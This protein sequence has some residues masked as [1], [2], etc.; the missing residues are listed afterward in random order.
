MKFLAPA[1]VVFSMVCFT[2]PNG[3]GVWVERSQV[4][5]VSHPVGCTPLARTKVELGNGTFVCITETV[6]EALQ[7]LD[8]G[9]K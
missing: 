5:T 1:L 4:V 8:A 7:R 3:F 6:K 9:S 2:D